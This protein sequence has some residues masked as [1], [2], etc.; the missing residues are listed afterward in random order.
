MR[1][2][3]STFSII[4][5]AC[6]LFTA[7]AG[8]SSPGNTILPL[9]AQN[10]AETISYATD[11]ASLQ[12]QYPGNNYG[13]QPFMNYVGDL[14][15]AKR[16]G[17]YRFDLPGIPEDAV[18][19]SAELH[20][21]VYDET[22][23]SNEGVILAVHHVYSSYKI[24]GHEWN[25]HEVNWSNMPILSTELNL[26]AESE[27]AYVDGMGHNFWVSLSVTEMVSAEYSEG[28]DD[29]SILIKTSFD[30]EDNQSSSDYIKTRTKE[31]IY[32][33]EHPYIEVSYAPTATRSTNWSD[34]KALY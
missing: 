6:T 32:T 24:D 23:E 11:D 29:I 26:A 17:I 15:S 9:A 7:F 13:T 19:L 12:R 3:Q 5:L 22:F 8:T 10:V 1:L 34:V 21:Y 4:L 20:L 27:W 16:S 18:I 31:S 14:G 25:E 33:Q 28:I 2:P 30:W